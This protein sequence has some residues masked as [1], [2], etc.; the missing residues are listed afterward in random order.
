M[1]GK[2]VLCCEHSCCCGGGGGGLGSDFDWIV[3]EF[4]VGYVFVMGAEGK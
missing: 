4:D 1:V 3:W 2:L